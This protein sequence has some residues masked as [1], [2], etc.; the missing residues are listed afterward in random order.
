MSDRKKLSI[1]KS[2]FQKIS[3]RV[4]FEEKNKQKVIDM[5]K[6]KDG[7]KRRS[8]DKI[9]ENKQRNLKFEKKLDGHQTGNIFLFK[10]RRK[11][12]S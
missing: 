10:N 8:S 7:Q 3:V 11:Q 5:R 4:N 9:N 12:R 2:T 6:K 1:K